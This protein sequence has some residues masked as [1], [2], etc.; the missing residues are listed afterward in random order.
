MKFK[1]KNKKEIQNI[2]Q[3]IKSKSGLIT[4]GKK[5]YWFITLGLLPFGM[6][7]FL[8]IQL[9]VIPLKVGLSNYYAPIWYGEWN[10]RLLVIW[11]TLLVIGGIVKLIFTILKFLFWKKG[12]KTIKDNNSK[13]PKKAIE[14]M[15]N[16]I[17]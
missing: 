10:T 3:S 4:M 13:L 1:K 8:L 17:T 16:V 15:E 9:S 14:E 6:L 5:F 12:K 11:V 7:I 2:K